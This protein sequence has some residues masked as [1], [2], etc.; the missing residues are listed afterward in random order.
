VLLIKEVAFGDAVR[1]IK[2]CNSSGGVPI[3][4]VSAYLVD[5]LLVDS[6]CNYG[7]RELSELLKT[8]KLK[9][10]INTHHHEDH[11]AGNR[12]LQSSRRLSTFAH[13]WAVPL[14]RLRPKLYSY[15]E[16]AWGYPDPSEAVPI[17]ETV[18]SENHELRVIH[19]PGHSLDHIALIEPKE[20]WAFVGDSFISIKP[21]SARLDENQW[22]ILSSLKKIREFSPRMLFTAVTDPVKDASSVLDQSIEIRE[23]MGRRIMR[24]S[25]EGLNTNQILSE[26]FGKEAQSSLFGM[27][28][29]YKEFTSGQYCTENLVETFIHK[30][31]YFSMN[32]PEMSIPSEF[33]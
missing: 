18:N 10:I 19:V 23:E 3:M 1:Q 33:Q 28:A 12:L 15:Q 14:L 17:G 24:L 31:H 20:G 9:A 22:L 16:L 4:W 7:K 11:I 25:D 32:F 8:R 13:P 5:D 6:G 30:Q 29:T 27:K 26:V 21:T 2:T